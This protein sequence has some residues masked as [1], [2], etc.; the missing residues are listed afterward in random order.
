M[1]KTLLLLFL[2]SPLTF[3]AGGWEGVAAIS[4]AI[5]AAL[6]GILYMVGTGFSINELQL[7][8]KEELYQL[9]ALM[10]MLAILVSSNN[11]LDG[12]SSTFGAI[13]G[14]PT[15][16]AAGESIIDSTLTEPTKGVQKVFTT[17]TE[18]DNKVAEES[19]KTISCSILGVGYTVSSCGGYSMLSAPLSMAGG[20]AGFAIGELYAMKRLIEISETYAMNFLLPLGILL[21]TFKMSRGAGGFLIALGISMHIMLPAGIIFNQMLA[22]TF[23]ADPSAAGYNAA[24]SADLSDC[25][26][27]NIVGFGFDSEVE[28]GQRDLA[29]MEADLKKVLFTV[30]IRATLGPVIALLML[31][32]SVRALTSLAGAEVDVS[33]ISRFI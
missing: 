8:A 14:Q 27:A 4:V 28:K 2:L 22:D 5:S 6:L 23:A 19:S 25:D 20:I 11:L 18:Y 24:M 13:E 31:A 3:A 32:A 29:A 21:R 10:L 9:L 7:M 1:R 26:P 33:S 12:L 16:Q 17:I 30:L 15:M